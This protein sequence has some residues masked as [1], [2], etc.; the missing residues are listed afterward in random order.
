[1]DIGKIRA[2][3]NAFR[4]PCGFGW[5][6]KCCIVIHRSTRVLEDDVGAASTSQGKELYVEVL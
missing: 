5:E 3:I 1:V 4:I 6:E 2:T